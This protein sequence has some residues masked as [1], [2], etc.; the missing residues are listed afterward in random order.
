MRR[1][2]RNTEL[3]RTDN[4]DDSKMLRVTL[5]RS[6]IETRLELDLLVQLQK[7]SE[8]FAIEIRIETPNKIKRL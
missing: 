5:F 7:K 1:N 4:V 2:G 8:R 6:Q 3:I